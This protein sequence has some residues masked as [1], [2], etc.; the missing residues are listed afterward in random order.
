MLDFKHTE[1]KNK[2]LVI[3]EN[4]SLSDHIE[5]LFA[6]RDWLVESMST[7]LMIWQG[8]SS[9]IDYRCVIFVIDQHF[10]KRFSGLITE[11]S[12]VIRNASMHTPVYLLLENDDDTMFSAWLNHVKKTFKLATGQHGLHEAIR[13]I[14]STE[15]PCAS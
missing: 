12:A 2:T 15:A 9:A 8:A 4:G 5:N 7:H 13:S 11:M 6:D 14:V 1:L 3:S 10:R